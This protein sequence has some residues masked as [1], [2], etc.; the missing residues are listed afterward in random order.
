MADDFDKQVKKVVEILTEVSEK[1]VKKITLDVTANLIDTTPVDVG[2]ARAN[3]VPAIGQPVVQ[4]VATPESVSTAAQQ[5]GIVSVAT[6][7]R[8][9]RGN[10]FVSNNVRYITRLNEGSSKQAPAG[11]VQNAITKAVRF[12]LT[13]IATR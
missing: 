11:F 2:W 7:Y 9:D 6:S 8:L 3:W 13:G 5:A 12:D 1:V 4:P 10:V